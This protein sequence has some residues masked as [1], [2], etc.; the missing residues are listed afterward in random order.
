[1]STAGTLRCLVA[2]VLKIPP[3]LSE[4][5]RTLVRGIGVCYVCAKRRRVDIYIVIRL[6]LEKVFTPHLHVDSAIRHATLFSV[7]S[8][9][10]GYRA[11]HFSLPEDITCLVGAP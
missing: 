9:Y 4:V 8:A 11:R 10:R 7:R 5:F 6:A 3:Y 1:M 2:K